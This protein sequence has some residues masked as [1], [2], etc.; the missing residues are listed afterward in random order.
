MRFKKSF[1][2]LF[3]LIKVLDG[4]ISNLLYSF[5]FFLK[6]LNFTIFGKKESFIT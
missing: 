3:F 2:I 1:S 5:N 4:K 6:V